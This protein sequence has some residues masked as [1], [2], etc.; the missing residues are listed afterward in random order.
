[1]QQLV[2]L[3]RVDAHDGLVLGDEAF[4][5]HVDGHLQRRGSGALAVAGL[6][7]VELLVLDGELHVL[8]VAVVL[9]EGVADLV[10]L[11]ERLRHDGLELG[12]RPRHAHAGHHVFAL[13]VHEELAVEEVLARGRVAGEGHAGAR[14]LALVAEDHALHVDGRAQIVGDALGAAVDLGAM[15]VPALEDRDHRHVQLLDGIIR[16]LLARALAQHLL[17]AHREVFQVVGGEVGVEL[18]ARLFLLLGEG[19]LEQLRVH[20]HDHVAEHADEAAVG[21]VGET[22]IA[23]ALGE[24]LDGLVVEAEVEHGVHHARHRED[25]AGAD[26]EQQGL[27]R[28]AEHLAGELLESVE[29][30]LDLLFETVGILAVGGVVDAGLGRNGEAL[31]N[32]DTKPGHLREVGA[33]TPQQ[34][35]HA[36]IAFGEIVDVLGDTHQY[37][38]LRHHT[39]MLLASLR[40]RTHPNLGP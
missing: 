38:S 9:L 33:L 3:G 35:L 5:D 15:V 1:M 25:G 26:G 4:G 37:Y 39:Y 13:G 20:A 21:V 29:M 7:H 36:G 27:G 34:G 8:H 22:G 40:V 17:E 14:R 32:G 19:V 10:E 2:E 31:R 16:E 6:Q 28:V 24:A 23:G 18:G 11:L 12:E 30:I